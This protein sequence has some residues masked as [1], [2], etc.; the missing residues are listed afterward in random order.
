[1][2]SLLHHVKL[3][4]T[5]QPLLQ[6]LQDLAVGAFASCC[7]N[8]ASHHRPPCSYSDR[9]KQSWITHM[10]AF[11]VHPSKEVLSKQNL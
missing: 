11:I 7:F 1:L 9:A 5:F 8:I 2:Y 4:L 10:T 6:A 3:F